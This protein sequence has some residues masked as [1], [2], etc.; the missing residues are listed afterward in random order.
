MCKSH[1]DLVVIRSELNSI[2]R[3]RDTLIDERYISNNLTEIAGLN[4]KCSMEAQEILVRQFAG[5]RV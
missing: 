1:E 2:G 4:D 5:V 3:L